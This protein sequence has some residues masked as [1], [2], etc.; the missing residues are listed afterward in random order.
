MSTQTLNHSTSTGPTRLRAQCFIRCVQRYK[1]FHYSEK[2]RCFIQS[3]SPGIF[4]QSEDLCHARKLAE[5]LRSRYGRW[6][7]VQQSNGVVRFALADN[8][9]H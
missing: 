7:W 8:P 9:D 3:F 4:T 1:L 5:G 6:L 2:Q